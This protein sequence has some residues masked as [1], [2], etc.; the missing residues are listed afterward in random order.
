[1]AILPAWLIEEGR[2]GS[3]ARSGFGRPNV[4]VGTYAE[5]GPLPWPP[6]SS[7]EEVHDE[8]LAMKVL[9]ACRLAKVDV[10]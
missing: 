5:F 8:V 7:I 3:V 9:V 10:K 4:P 1:M 2:S 6:N